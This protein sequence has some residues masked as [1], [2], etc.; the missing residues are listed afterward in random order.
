[1]PV[2]KNVFIFGDSI[3]YGEWDALG[4]WANRLRAYFD[5]LVLPL[6]H[7]YVITYNLGIPSDTSTGVAQRLTQETQSR[8][9]PNPGLKDIQFIIAI[10]TNDSR[11]LISDKK[12]GVE[13]GQ[14]KAN[15]EAITAAA[16]SFSNNIIFMGLLPCIEETV[17]ETAKR[18]EWVE[19]Y[20]NQSIQTYNE[21]IKQ[22]C[23]ESNLGFIDL[24]TPFKNN[25]IDS[26]FNDG[27][28]PNSIGH[29]LIYDVI[30]KQLDKK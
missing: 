9:T 12:H 27:L 11:W 22:H 10:G 13:P 21:I 4:G 1:M 30:V 17:Q 7:D 5:S 16:A 28:H 26:L 23:I 19:S 6:P 25:D 20:D 18:L 24:Y 29:S 15:I 2:K 3:A 8:L 14:F